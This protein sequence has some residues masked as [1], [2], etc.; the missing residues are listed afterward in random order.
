MKECFICLG[1]VVK[2][3]LSKTKKQ[4]FYCKPCKKS[5]T[6][7][8]EEKSIKKQQVLEESSAFKSLREIAKN[9]SV[10]PSTILKWIKRAN[11]SINLT[12]HNDETVKLSNLQDVI[13]SKK[14]NLQNAILILGGDVM[15]IDLNN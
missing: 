3:G 12:F 7:G 1:K 9:H 13:S 11:S 15:I 5:F 8:L 6:E 10:A 2:N 4:Q 14:E